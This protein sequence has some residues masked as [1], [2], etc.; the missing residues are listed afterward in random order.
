MRSPISCTLALLAAACA[1]PP[2]QE[3]GAVVPLGN[4]QVPP[5]AAALEPRARTAGDRSPP[6]PEVELPS[7]DAVLGHWQRAASADDQAAWRDEPRA[8]EMATGEPAA[9]TRYDPYL[10]P[11][12]RVRRS[13]EIWFPI[14]TVIGAGIG[15]AIGR[16][17]RHRWRGA[18]IG[19]GIG[20]MFDLHRLL[21]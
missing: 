8:N 16:H 4:D 12:W 14:D 7:A 21:R 19:G 15:S 18:W 1:A 3:R 6:L 10:D 20:L 11:Y 17:G 9:A 5:S 13:R 2:R